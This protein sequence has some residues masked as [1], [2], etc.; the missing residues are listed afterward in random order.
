MKFNNNSDV[1]KAVILIKKE[2]TGKNVHYPVAFKLALMTYIKKHGINKEKFAVE[3]DIGKSTLWTWG[4]QFE[5][6]LFSLEGA[7]N[8]SAK[9]K[10][11]NEKI[12]TELHQQLEELT[13][14]IR[15]VEA[16]E[17]MGLKLIA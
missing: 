14:K 4:K 9:S 1:S 6:G 2:K 12:L 7:Y 10:S 17:K 5:D 3:L 16:A 15:I 13:E 8:V 11:L